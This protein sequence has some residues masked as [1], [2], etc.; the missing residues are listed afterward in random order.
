M[1]KNAWFGGAPLQQIGQSIVEIKPIS[2]NWELDTGWLNLG[3]TDH[4][5]FMASFDWADLNN[6]QYGSKPANAQITGQNVGGELGLVEMYAEVFEKV[7]PGAKV[8]RWPDNTL[9]RIIARKVVGA[10]LTDYLYWYRFT[11]FRNGKK[12]TNHKDAIYALMATRMESGEINADLSPQVVTLPLVGFEAS[13]DYVNTP[14]L[15]PEDGET[16][17]FFWTKDTDEYDEYT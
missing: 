6:L 16:P 17:L 4:N 7:W 12:S 5:N 10:R 2:E 3:K 11:Q 14:V 15:D 13:A 1:A 8:I 9:K